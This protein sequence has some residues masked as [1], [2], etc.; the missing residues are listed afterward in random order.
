KRGDF[1]VSAQSNDKGVCKFAAPPPA[2]MVSQASSPDIIMTDEDV[3]PTNEGSLKV[4]AKGSLTY[5]FTSSSLS[6]ILS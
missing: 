5:H 6:C 2:S 3:R 1:V 4:A